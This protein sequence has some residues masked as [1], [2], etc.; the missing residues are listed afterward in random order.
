MGIRSVRPG[1]AIALSAWV[2]GLRSEQDI[3]EGGSEI[4]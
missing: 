1:S 3:P 2:L 4:A